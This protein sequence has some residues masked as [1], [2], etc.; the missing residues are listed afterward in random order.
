MKATLGFMKQSKS[1]AKMSSVYSKV[2][3]VGKKRKKREREK[4]EY[5]VYWMLLS[6]R[7]KNEFMY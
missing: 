4:P 3:R 7:I 2:Y 6:N 5:S 1:A